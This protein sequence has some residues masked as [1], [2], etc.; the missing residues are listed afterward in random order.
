M[1]AIV[2]PKGPAVAPRRAP[3]RRPK[4]T[5]SGSGHGGT[6]SVSK[7]LPL[8]AIDLPST[9]RQL[10]LTLQSA[11]PRIRG[12]LRT[13]LRAG[14]RVA[15]HP[16]CDEDAVRGLKLFC[17]APRMLLFRAPGETRV[18]PEE[19]DRRCDCFNAGRWVALLHEAAAAVT[20]APNARRSDTTSRCPG[21]TRNVPRPPR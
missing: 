18:P 7:P 16:A 15:V 8:D 6:R 20:L 2:V 12:A 21:Q 1:L 4:N 10:V 13:A 17:F 5:A 14:L 11:P 9:C 19:L 3:R